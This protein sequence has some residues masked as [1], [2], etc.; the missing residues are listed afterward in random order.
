[1]ILALRSVTCKSRDNPRKTLNQ[2]VL[3]HSHNQ[4]P[5]DLLG[6][7]CSWHSSRLCSV[8]LLADAMIKMYNHAFGR[9]RLPHCHYDCCEAN[10]KHPEAPKRLLSTRQEYC[11]GGWARAR[12]N[13]KTR[14]QRVNH[15]LNRMWT[16]QPHLLVSASLALP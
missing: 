10:R 11:M 5:L 6:L 15:I 14:G 1:M 7:V 3:V 9:Y 16:T 2:S 13:E 4:N 12:S 8:L